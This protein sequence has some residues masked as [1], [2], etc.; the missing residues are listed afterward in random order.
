MGG[1]L[2]ACVL[3]V[4]WGAALVHGIPA[5]AEGDVNARD[6]AGRPALLVAAR[7]GSNPGRSGTAIEISR[8]SPSE[9]E[10]LTC[11]QSVG[12]SSSI[13]SAHSTTQTPSPERISRIPI[14]SASRAPARR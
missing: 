6:A 9:K 13:R 7:S 8:R 10:N 14:S 4:L 11:I 2:R 3:G 12:K 5:W 1:K